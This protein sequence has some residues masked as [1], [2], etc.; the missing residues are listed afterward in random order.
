MTTTT[1]I[2]PIVTVK[3]L[4]EACG[5]SPSP[6]DSSSL[7]NPSV[8]LCLFVIDPRRRNARRY[9]TETRCAPGSGGEL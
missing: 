2:T 8:H 5:L 3:R 4:P 7:F 1:A 6:V 9:G